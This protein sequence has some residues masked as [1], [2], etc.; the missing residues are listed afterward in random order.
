MGGQPGPR[1]TAGAAAPGSHRPDIVMAAAADHSQL[2][3]AVSELLVLIGAGPALPGRTGGYPA[4]PAASVPGAAALRDRLVADVL[5][6]ARICQEVVLP[7]AWGHDII[8]AVSRVSAGL[9]R[10]VGGAQ[11]LAQRQPGAP[12]FAA[13]LGLLSREVDEHER[14]CG[15]VL[16]RIRGMGPARR[17]ELWER[18][19][20]LVPDRRGSSGI[21]QHWH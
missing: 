20:V 4:L 17:A 2:A 18:A 16:A 10:L 13:S 8:S 1:D 3:A 21:S 15:P 11:V 14:D 7:A 19:R 5:D 9:L 6:H 12:L